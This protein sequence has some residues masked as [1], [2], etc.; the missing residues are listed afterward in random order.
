MKA[1]LRPLFVVAAL[2][3]A[4]CV[5]ASPRL[6]QIPMVW[7]PT[8]VVTVP[9]PVAAPQRTT[10]ALRPLMDRRQNP[11]AIGENREDADE[12]KILPVTSRDEIGAWCTDRLMVLLTQGGYTLVDGDQADLT[13]SGE[14]LQFYVVET[15]TY[16]STVSLR[17][18]LSNR[19]GQVVWSGV[20][21]GTK[22]RFGRSYK[23]ENYY[24]VLSDAYLGAVQELLVQPT[25][26]STLVEHAGGR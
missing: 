7:K 17:L 21:T 18:T 2:M 5:D 14:V 1:Y 19:D 8:D 13:L 11:A 15:S 12:G 6:E 26:Q 16:K 10:I 22:Q 25:F 3:A 4:A 24:E 23:A 20:G 9:P